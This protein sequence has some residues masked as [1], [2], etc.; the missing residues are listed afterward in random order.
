MRC[1]GIGETENKIEELRASGELNRIIKEMRLELDEWI[2][3]D[4]MPSNS[5]GEEQLHTQFLE[6]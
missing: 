4:V 3:Y 1:K 2:Q 6:L 5:P